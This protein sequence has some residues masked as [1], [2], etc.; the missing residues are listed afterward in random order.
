MVQSKYYSGICHKCLRKSRKELSQNSRSLS[1]D[2]NR[3]P[4]DFKAITLH[5][6]QPAQMN[7]VN[8]RIVDGI[9]R[10]QISDRY[11]A[12]NVSLSGGFRTTYI[13]IFSFLKCIPKFR[14]E[15]S[16]FKTRSS[17][18]ALQTTNWSGMF[19][20]VSCNFALPTTAE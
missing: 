10:L 17:V 2:S 14:L 16:V 12:I 13:L 4:I 7:N 9:T 19:W 6:H 15:K 11:F 8:T 18:P 20:Q 3:A 5:L 1:R